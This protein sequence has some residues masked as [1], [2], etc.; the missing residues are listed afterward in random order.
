MRCW[1]KARAQETSRQKGRVFVFVFVLGQPGGGGGGGAAVASCVTG[2][3]EVCSP[4]ARWDVRPVLAGSVHLGL[5][6]FLCLPLHA[7]LFPVQA[8]HG[9]L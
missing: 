3:T 5:R 4:V 2:W 9:Y 8:I 1:R 7:L 6:G